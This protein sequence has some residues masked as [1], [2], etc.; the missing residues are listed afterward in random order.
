MAHCC[1]Y[2]F[3]NLGVSLVP[4]RDPDASLYPLVLGNIVKRGG[5]SCGP[6]TSLRRSLR[7][8]ARSPHWE[9]TAGLTGA[10]CA[11]GTAVR[12]GGGEDDEHYRAMRSPARTC[13]QA[14]RR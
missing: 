3:V 11:A 10:G 14:H 7:S 5:P 8:L 2:A 12:V 9:A 4:P 6:R 1:S 13:Q